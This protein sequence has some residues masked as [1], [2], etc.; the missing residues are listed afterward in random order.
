MRDSSKGAFSTEFAGQGYAT[1]ALR[2]IIPGVFAILDEENDSDSLDERYIEAR[3]MA[4]NVASQRVLVK[5]GFQLWQ[6]SA[7]ATQE[8]KPDIM[9]Y[10]LAKADAVLCL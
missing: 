5:C 2:A 7:Q 1:E 8:S 10:R 9:T 4:E 3:T 6:D